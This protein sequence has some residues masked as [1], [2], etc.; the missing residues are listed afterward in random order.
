M[1]S[2]I[3]PKI[4]KIIQ[5]S[6]SFQDFDSEM[7]ICMCSTGQVESFLTTLPKISCKNTGFSCRNPK[8]TKN[9]LFN[10]VFWHF[11][12]VH[13]D[14]C[15]N[16]PDYFFCQNPKKLIESPKEMIIV[17]NT[18]I[19]FFSKFCWGHVKCNLATCRNFLPKYG[20]FRSET[21]NDQTITLLS[22]RAPKHS[23]ARVGCS[24]EQF[25]KKFTPKIQ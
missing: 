20:N 18:L 21:K 22:K 13:L 24:F 7:L 23:A 12:P 8:K 10:K 3:V 9:K 2:A 19:I 17:K 6:S 15:F 16:T 5:K 4:S 25:D 11:S 14:Y 1:F